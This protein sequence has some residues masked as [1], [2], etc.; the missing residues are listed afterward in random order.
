MNFRLFFC[1][2]L[3]LCFAASVSAAPADSASKAKAKDA[4]KEGAAVAVEE[5][6][7]FSQRIQSILASLKTPPEKPEKE[8]KT[9]IFGQ[10][11]VPPEQIV[12]YILQRNP[13][14]KLNCTVA[15]LVGYYYEE[16]S[17]EGIR[18]DL[19]ISQAILETD[20]FRYGG[21]VVPEQN[22]YA[23][24]GTTGGGVKGAFFDSPQIGVRA[25]IQHLL[26]YAS[27]RQPSLA[28]VDPRYELLKAHP[29][30]FG[31][32]SNWEDLNGR[33]AV[34]GKNYSQN[35]FRTLS[36]INTAPPQPT[37][38]QPPV[39]AWRATAP[40]VEKPGNPAPIALPAPGVT[41][42][43]ANAAAE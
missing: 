9:P 31:R 4:K 34:P 6:S 21:D 8:D 29:D 13:Q 22:N 14:P 38:P 23:G 37:V 36:Y 20:C 15:E 16:A 27:S 5:P 18:P 11:Q 1:S 32:C 3:L 26:G 12:A 33:W 30:K 35:I 41:A 19:A 39:T 43:D 28:I 40:P 42:Q 10:A 7:P 2:L 17:R 24:I 25:Q